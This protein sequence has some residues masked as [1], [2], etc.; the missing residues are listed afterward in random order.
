MIIL[1]CTRE[2]HNNGHS[3]SHEE[4]Q[5]NTSLYNQPQCWNSWNRDQS[6]LR[7]MWFRPVS[8]IRMTHNF[9]NC[10]SHT[11][12]TVKILQDCNRPLRLILDGKKNK[13]F[14]SVFSNPANLFMAILT[15]GLY[16]KSNALR[17]SI[18]HVFLDWYCGIKSVTYACVNMIYLWSSNTYTQNE[19]DIKI[20][21]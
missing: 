11:C 7:K 5:F 3:T 21:C 12:L 6:K 9:V 10:V 15:S 1:N 16:I 2:V 4:C 19:L 13:N 8:A 14:T 18:H 17:K 20:L